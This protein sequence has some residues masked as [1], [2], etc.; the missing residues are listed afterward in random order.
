MPKYITS[1]LEDTGIFSFHVS[2]MRIFPRKI[3]KTC[4]SRAGHRQTNLFLCN[5]II[6][7]FIAVIF[8]NAFAAVFFTVLYGDFTPPPPACPRADRL[9]ARFSI[10]QGACNFEPWFFGLLKCQE[11]WYN[12]FK[13]LFTCTYYW[14]IKKTCYL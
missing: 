4:F 13:V 12:K 9:P 14:Y 11:Q 2:H 7:R 5:H 1:F 3:C 6:W 10:Y 8:K